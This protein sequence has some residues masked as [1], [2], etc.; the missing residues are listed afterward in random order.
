M[1]RTQSLF[2]LIP[3]MAA[4]PLT[5]CLQESTAD[6]AEQHHGPAVVEHV[7]GT[8]LGRIT[9]TPRAAERLGVQTSPVRTAPA[10]SSDGAGAATVMPY[11]ALLYDAHGDT[12]TYTNPA[13]HVFIRHPITVDRIAGDLAILVAGPP[14]GTMVVSVGAAELFGTEFDVGH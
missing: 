10:A 2:V 3:I 8:D 1:P 7:D 5:G 14:P 4:L 9:L 6:A 12:W 13:P 11:G